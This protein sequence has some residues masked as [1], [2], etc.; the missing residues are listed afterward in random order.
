MSD[1]P[2]GNCWP[3]GKE[4]ANRKL[5]ERLGLMQRDLKAAQADVPQCVLGELRQSPIAALAPSRP[6]ELC[7]LIAASKAITRRRST[8]VM[9]VLAE[10][11]F[12]VFASISASRFGRAFLIQ[13]VHYSLLRPF[14]VLLHTRRGL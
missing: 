3:L 6:E 10:Y 4:R 9:A 5:P 7:S 2:S 12:S 8:L 1:G 11:E 13:A 14:V